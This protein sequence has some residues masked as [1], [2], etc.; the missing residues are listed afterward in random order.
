MKAISAS[1]SGAALMVGGLSSAAASTTM[2]NTYT[3][4][5]QTATDGWVYGFC[6]N[7][8][9][10]NRAIAYNSANPQA[11]TAGG[12][13]KGGFYGTDS[14][15]PTAYTSIL[16][17]GYGGTSHLNWGLHLTSA[18]DTAEI[19]SADS[20][21][22]YGYAAEIDT[23]GGAWRDD[24]SNSQGVVTG[25]KHQTDIGL[26]KSDVTQNVTLNL[27]NLNQAFSARFGITVFEGMDQKT[28]AY[29]HHG[30]WNNVNPLP[31][32]PGGTPPAQIVHPYD[33]NNPFGTIGLTY[34]D[35]SD[36]VDSTAAN[37][38]TFTAEAGK[39][40]SIYLGGADFGD[41]NDNLAN[42][43]LNVTTS[44]VPV[45][46]AVW[47]FGSALAGLGVVRKRGATKAA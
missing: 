27:T 4:A 46:G 38:F 29:V 25:W 26:V 31:A 7:C 18:G 33:M 15:N 19:S 35:H 21:S 12:A 17:F 34:M 28:T 16:P 37:A 40:Y 23:G 2:Y 39:V 41:W 32:G 8:A 20:Q 30:S 24:G 6:T 43:K 45:P 10:N 22:R 5:N 42:Y 44:P 47:L 3:T 13:S 1:L 9:N 14:S 11:Y 36:L